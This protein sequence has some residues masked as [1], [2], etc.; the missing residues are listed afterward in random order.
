MDINEPR[1]SDDGRFY[2]DGERWTVT[3][4][5]VGTAE[6]DKAEPSTPR[7]SAG[8]I[9]FGIG[10]A[11]ILAPICY[12]FAFAFA[13]L[14]AGLLVMAAFIT[15]AGAGIGLRGIHRLLRTFDRLGGATV[16]R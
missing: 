13:D 7:A 2:W 14:K 6:T 5:A 11:G 12:I 9:A 4:T 8:D 1:Y 3:D 10:M 16:H 15:A